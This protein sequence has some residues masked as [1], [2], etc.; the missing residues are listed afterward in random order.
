VSVLVDAGGRAMSADRI[1]RISWRRVGGLALRAY[2]CLFLAGCAGT[3]PPPTIDEVRAMQTRTLDE[4]VETLVKATIS[5]LQ[6][7]GY[8]VDMI[9]TDVGLI[10]ASRRTDSEQAAVQAEPEAEK[11]DG[12][13][14]WLVV[15]SVILVVG[16]VIMVVAALSDDDE[17]KDKD[18]SA[19]QD[20]EETRSRDSEEHKK[21]HDGESQDTGTSSPELYVAL[22]EDP[23]ATV[24][25]YRV[26][27]NLDPLQE[28]PS[29]QVRVSC[30]ATCYQGGSMVEAGPVHAPAF[31]KQ[32]FTGLNESLLREAPTK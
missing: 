26:T 7:L 3:A 22:D 19:D 6:D 2:L 14:T 31:Y 30:E 16:I 24:Y 10:T 15:L 17:D 18:K 29:C 1:L 5:V 23:E 9:Q 27:V 25:E 8:T 20:K 32:F 12:A 28:G 21:K 13:P 11:K 4:D